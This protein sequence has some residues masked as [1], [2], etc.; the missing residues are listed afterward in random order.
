M[1]SKYSL[2]TNEKNQ[3]KNITSKIKDHIKDT[4]IESG[5][6][7]VYCPHTTAAITI[8]E[9]ADPAV[10]KDVLQALDEQVP[11]I[12]FDHAEGNSDA[13]LKSSIIGCSEQIPIKNSKLQLGNWQKVYFCE[14]DGPRSRSFYVKIIG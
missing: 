11:N 1:F 12:D 4:G 6:C 13:H 10:K 14:F 8:N 5:I 9:G 2:R 7:L 3:M